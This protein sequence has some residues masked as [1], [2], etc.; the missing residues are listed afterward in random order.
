MPTPLPLLTPAVDASGKIWFLA[1]S[2]TEQGDTR[3]DL[4]YLPLDGEG[5][6]ERDAPELLP[7]SETSWSQRG[8]PSLYPSPSG[9]YLA[10]IEVPENGPGD[11]ITIVDVSSGETWPFYRSLG[12]VPPLGRFGGWH[13]DGRHVLYMDQENRTGLWLVDVEGKDSPQHL[14]EHCPDSAA[15]S[16]D[17]QRLAFVERPILSDRSELWL[18]WSDGSHEK[19]I[20][21][22][23]RQHSSDR[24]ADG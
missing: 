18:A 22:I 21:D 2:E 3:W 8:M 1:E 11:A 5:R 23:S 20:F 10:I 7:V 15:I 12:R 17:G 13:P 4:Y 16:P 24:R 14:S 19:K 6:P 9:Q